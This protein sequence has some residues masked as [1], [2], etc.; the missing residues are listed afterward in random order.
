MQKAKI[1][2]I[3]TH[4]NTKYNILRYCFF[5]RWK[6][7]GSYDL[8]QTKLYKKKLSEILEEKKVG[9]SCTFRYPEMHRQYL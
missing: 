4:K 5:Y 8:D 2:C 1:I 7:T 9:I 6:E 3:Y